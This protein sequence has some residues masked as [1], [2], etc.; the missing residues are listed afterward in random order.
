[1]QNPSKSLDAS[2]SDFTLHFIKVNGVRKEVT[3]H[4]KAQSG[5][6]QNI[7]FSY[8]SCPV[9]KRGL[10]I[11]DVFTFVGFAYFITTDFLKL[12]RTLSV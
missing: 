3:S 9:L 7:L 8:T 4:V 10:Y 1:M 11:S 5:H 2:P 12:F 6:R